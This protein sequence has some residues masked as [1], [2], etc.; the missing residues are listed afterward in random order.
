MVRK[1]YVSYL[2]ATILCIL[3]MMYSLLLFGDSQVNWLTREDGLVE[4]LGAFFFVG[5]SL[6]FFIAYVLSNVAQVA[7][8]RTGKK[9][10]RNLFYLGLCILFLFCFLEEI[11]W[12]QRLFGLR[13]PEILVEHN[14][15]REINVHNLT[16]FHGI[17]EEG[18]RK[19]F[20]RLLLNMDRLFSVFWLCFCVLIPFVDKYVVRIRRMMRRARVP[21]VPGIFAI[22]FICNY[23]MS[24]MLETFH[25]MNAHSIVEI[26]ESNFA[27]L[28]ACAAIGL[29]YRTVRDRSPVVDELSAGRAEGA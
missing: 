25:G 20:W 12:G 15:Q 1:R 8:G 6:V 16:W 27:F 10:R 11:S 24:K 22:L 19:S 14:R 3:C 18:N 5:S 29:L 26:K 28:F 21:I 17:D 2:T 9:A 13:T 23:L 4:T 7:T